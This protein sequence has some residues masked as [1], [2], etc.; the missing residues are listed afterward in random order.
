MKSRKL[1]LSLKEIM[2]PVSTI[3][4]NSG[5]ISKS[6]KILNIN[7]NPIIKANLTV[8]EYVENK[9]K[10][11]KIEL[12]NTYSQRST[13]CVKSIYE[14]KNMFTNQNMILNK[15]KKIP[16]IKLKNEVKSSFNIKQKMLLKNSGDLY[17]HHLKKINIVKTNIKRDKLP[18]NFTNYKK[19]SFNHSNYFENKALKIKKRKSIRHKYNN[20]ITGSTA[21]SLVE[22]NQ[23]YEI[24]NNQQP[25]KSNSVCPL[26]KYN[27]NNIFTIDSKN[28]N[29]NNI[30]YYSSMKNKFIGKKSLSFIKRKRINKISELTNLLHYRTE[31]KKKTTL[32]L[33][34]NSHCNTDNR[35]Y[36]KK[37]EFLE[38]E[39]QTLRKELEETK[40]KISF[41]LE[42]NS[43]NKT[44]LEHK[45]KNE[46]K[47]YQFPIPYVKKYS[48][49]NF[50]SINTMQKQELKEILIKPK[51]SKK[52]FKREFL[53]QNIPKPGYSKKNN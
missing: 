49:N 26:S 4:N 43:I 36:L 15:N 21:Y 6:K 17:K 52:Q 16:E 24:S 22:N 25:S 30:N 27:L 28:T 11:N 47:K 32:I 13:K 19:L 42:T 14:L 9:L 53:R 34:R 45:T 44:Y 48:Y 50:H 46:L 3:K 29:L 18:C 1:N 35:N 12:R 5:K 41:L 10:I 51:E 33:K 39:N 23:L 31:H 40:I 8:K 37:L 2:E 7:Y 38:K 20:S